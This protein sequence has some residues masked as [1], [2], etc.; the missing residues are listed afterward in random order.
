MTAMLVLVLRV[1]GR[2]PGTAGGETCIVSSGGGGDSLGGGCG[3][4]DGSV[5][6][7]SRNTR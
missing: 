5:I 1:S 4:N 2:S 3:G 6:S 7:Q